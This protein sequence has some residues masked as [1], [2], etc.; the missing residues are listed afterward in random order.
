LAVANSAR[1][2]RA[3]IKKTNETLAFLIELK[4]YLSGSF[5]D[6]AKM[7]EII[8]GITHPRQSS[9]R[10]PRH[11]QASSLEVIREVA[12]PKAGSKTGRPQATK[13]QK[14]NAC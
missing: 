14:N 10:L 1:D 8:C 11:L 12:A 7:L 4:K 6:A 9:R 2:K 13:F 5:F 3:K